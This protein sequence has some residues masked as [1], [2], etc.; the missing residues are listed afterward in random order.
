MVWIVMENKSYD[1]VIGSSRAPYINRLAAECGLATNFQA[2]AHPS[3]PNYV[4]M[5]SG[6]TQGITDDADP[7]AHRLGA[8]SIFSLLGARWRSLEDSM[9]ANCAG[10]DAELYAVRHN[11]ATYY[12]GVADSCRARD[13]PLGAAPDLSAAFTYITPNLCH[14]MHPCPSTP[15][16]SAQTAAGDSWLAGFVP[17]LL[18]S[19]E[20][21]SG[22]IAVFLTWD[23]GEGDSQ[24]IATLVLSPSTPAGAR[25]SRPLNHYS[26]LR[27]T[28]DLL[29]LRPYLGQAASAT[30]MALDFRLAP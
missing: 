30:S 21:R 7:G 8:P 29:A 15:D 17:Q 25:S 5:T 26:M 4:A 28:Q 11:P 12:T 27:T 13:V 1:E 18:A 24:R 23:E 14:D 16:S 6:S 20:Y 2:E 9:P 3:L 19:R 22:T 10:A